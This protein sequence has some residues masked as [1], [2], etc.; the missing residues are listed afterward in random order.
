M[1]R[2]NDSNDGLVKS[3]YSQENNESGVTESLLVHNSRSSKQYGSIKLDEEFS[4]NSEELEADVLELPKV[5]RETVPLQD[6]HTIPVLTFRYFLLSTLF[7]IPGAFIDTM[8]SYRTTSAAYSIFFV[9]IVSHWAGKWLAKTLPN[10]RVRIF[11]FKFDLNPGPW[12]IKETAMI[13]ITANSGATGNL[14]T[15]A[16]SLADLH[17]GETVNPMVALAFM[18]AIVFVGYS[19]AAICKNLLLYDPQYLWP[20]ALMQTTLLQS[21][22]KSDNE[23]RDGS[24]Q[25]KVF[26]AVLLGVAVWQLFPE[27]IFPMTSSLAVLC[28][29]APYN[30]TIN[31]IGS[32]MGGMGVFNFSLDWANITSSIM[33]YPYWIQ[34][35]QF[36]GF[37][38]G[39]WI[40]IP[41]VKWGNLGIFDGGLMSPSLFLGNGTLYPVKELLTEDLQFNATAYELY[42]PVHLG[43]QRAWNIFFDYAAYIS[44]ILWVVLFGYDKFK[45]AYDNLINKNHEK[46]LYTDRINKLQAKYREVPI[47]W[48]VTLFLI[49]FGTLMSIFVS[50]EM[51]M[52]WWCCLVALIMGSIIVTPLAW[53]YALSNF[54]LAIGTF[55]ELVYGY[56]MQNVKYKHPAGALVFGSIAGDAWYRAQYHLQCM[57]LGFYIHLPPRAVF[58]SQLYG[59]L[60]GIPIN[61]FALRWVLSSKRHFLD[62]SVQDP[63]H[64]WTGQA[65]TISHTNAIQYVVLG[66]SKLF[67]NYPLLP[68]GFVLGLVAPFILFA[69]YKKF[70]ASK[71]NFNLWNTTVLFSTMSTFYGNLSTGYLSRF[72]GGTV[73]MYWAFNYKHKYWKKYNYILAA[74]FDTGYN[75]AILLIFVLVATGTVMQMPHWWGNNETSVERCFAF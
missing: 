24:K 20:Q 58:F 45:L 36:V 13:T 63:L 56:I 34:V 49:S 35:I 8:N 5:L 25:M 69:L 9:Q 2:D 4:I 70:P 30:E 28:W 14:A 26:F 48:Y 64:Q 39:A 10:K 47:L 65:I 16:I 72:I 31:F 37:V 75:L 29:M 55:N 17:F 53:L 19:Y 23:S 21:Q 71:F 27:F 12:S 66:P 41:V 74:A 7:V 15:S 38:I 57:R 1:A 44:G 11:G 68:Y 6:D 33:L 61:Y 67:T 50:G 42:G 62:G 51:F 22:A 18:F 3:V 46:V 59:E 32:G 54:Q 40:L 52:P 43:A 73:T 60:I